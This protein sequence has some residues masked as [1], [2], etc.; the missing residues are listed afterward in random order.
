CR[1]QGRA[2]SPAKYPAVTTDTNKRR[3]LHT[4]HVRPS[5]SPNRFIPQQSPQKGFR[6]DAAAPRST[7]TCAATAAAAWRNPLKRRRT[8]LSVP[9]LGLSQQVVQTK[10]SPRT[11]RCAPS[12]HVAYQGDDENQVVLDIR[13]LE[14]RQRLLGGT[15][16]DDGD[17]VD[18]SKKSGKGRLSS[19]IVEVPKLRKGPG[20]TAIRTQDCKLS[21]EGKDHGPSVVM[22][23]V[24]PEDREV[25]RSVVLALGGF[26]VEAEVTPGTTHLVVGGAVRTLN[27]LSAMARGCWVLS[28]DW[29]Y[30]SL[31][32]GHWL[33]E[34][35]FELSEMFPAVRLSRQDRAERRHGEGGLLAGTGAFYVSPESR[36]PPDKLRQLVQILGGKLAPSYLRCNVALGPVEASR[37]RPGVRHVSEKWLL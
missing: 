27:L 29:V 35:P 36:P 34:C 8:T 30:R 15:L 6:H 13:P 25:L 22:T 26:R 32:A 4:K 7:Q 33:D 28:M 9:F 14:R 5:L 23:S 11:K 12:K 18:E 1:V 20:A 3:L 17:F 37:R 10:A 19:G 2:V 16:L 24:P 21:Q 31:E